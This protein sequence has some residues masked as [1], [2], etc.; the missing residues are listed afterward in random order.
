MRQKYVIE[1]NIKRSMILFNLFQMQLGEWYVI[2]VVS[3]DD[4]ELL[5]SVDVRS[6]FWRLNQ[7]SNRAQY[8][9]WIRDT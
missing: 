2:V 5:I 3:M 6:H 9:T 4:T 1:T 8:Y 7:R